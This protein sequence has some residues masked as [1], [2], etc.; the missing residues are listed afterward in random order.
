MGATMKKYLFDNDLGINLR[1]MPARACKGLLAGCSS[2]HGA[3]VWATLCELE[4]IFG[5]PTTK[6]KIIGADSH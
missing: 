6:A 2:Y 4:Q 5:D 1:T 3:K